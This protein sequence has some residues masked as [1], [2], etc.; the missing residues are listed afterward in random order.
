M[1]F[2]TWIELRLKHS[3]YTDERCPDFEIEP[4]PETQ[5]LLNN[6]RCVFKTLPDG[7]RILIATTDDGTSSL[8]P[9]QPGMKLSFYLRLQNSDFPLFT[10]MTRV[11]G[12]VAPVYCNREERAR[13][14]LT[15]C[16]PQSTESFMVCQPDPKER[17]ILSGS[18]LTG[19]DENSFVITGLGNTT[20]PTCYNETAK[21]ITVNS[22]D[23]E[24]GTPF[25]VTYPS[26]P[27]LKNGVF[28]DIEIMENSWQD[29]QMREKPDPS[30]KSDFWDWCLEQL[31][32]WDSV[33]NYNEQQLLEID[34]CPY[35][36]Y[37]I[38][39]RAKEAKWKYYLITDDDAST[40]FCIKDCEDSPL[41]FSGGPMESEQIAKDNIAQM[42]AEQYPDM[43]LFCFISDKSIACQQQARKSIKLI[44]LKLGESSVLEPLP[45]PSLR[46]Y[47]IMNEPEECFLF[48]VI[49]YLTHCKLNNQN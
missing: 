27:Q 40:E 6:Y 44:K 17:F 37:D 48:Q 4:T 2:I 25:S 41:V 21:I 35:E 39:F 7:M 49:K 8:I 13:L 30:K 24:Q 45:N 43:Q 23:T 32:F 18:P 22:K 29:T 9:L 12:T 16:P 26:T 11:N 1:K 33:N 5:K 34:N 28:A 14:V 15:S 42:L 3:Y 19:L 46:N 36:F 38:Q 31:F 10:D 20:N 47:A